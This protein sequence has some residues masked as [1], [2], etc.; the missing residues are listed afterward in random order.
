MTNYLLDHNIRLDFKEPKAS[1]LFLPHSSLLDLLLYFG[2]VGLILIT[3]PLIKKLKGKSI[4]NNI[5][6]YI[7]IFLIINYSKSDSVIYIQ[8]FM[9]IF[10]MYLKIL[11]GS[12][13]KD[14]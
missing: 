8:G 14:D 2:V 10:V 3:I 12:D 7:L 1:S 5:F 9:L 6:I 4:L 11:I 13:V